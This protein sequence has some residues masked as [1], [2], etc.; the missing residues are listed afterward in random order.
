MQLGNSPVLQP[1]PGRPWAHRA[2]RFAGGAALRALSR[3]EGA[4]KARSSERA[5]TR[6]GP[7]QPGLASP[8]AR[9]CAA[10]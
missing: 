6:F 9:L 5:P 1:V 7:Q 4:G 2:P 3:E 8:Q 10:L